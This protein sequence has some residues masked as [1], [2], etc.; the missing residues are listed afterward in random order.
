[1]GNKGWGNEDVLPFFKRSEHNENFGEP[2]HGK[3]GPLNVTHSQQP[4]PMGEA[5]IRACESNGIMR[6]EDYNGAE[7][8]GASMLQFTIKNNLR[9][10]TA[11]AFLKPVM[12]RNNLTVKT[13]C[14]VNRILID[15][16]RATGVEVI[17]SP[18]KMET[19]TC[20]REVI[21]SAGAIQSPQV[22][23]LSG[24]GDRDVLEKFGIPVLKHL[25][26]VG[27]N[28]Q[29][30]VWSGI[31]GYTNIPMGNSLIR[32]WP[33]FKAF[34]QHLIFKK[35]PLGNSPLEAN[36]FLK[37]DHSLLRPDIQFHMAP[38]AIAPGYSTDIYKLD[39]FAKKDGYGILVILLRPESKGYITLRS[40]NPLDAPVI[41]P[42]FFSDKRDLEV[43]L[44]ALKKSLAIASDFA[45][46][47]YAPGPI[48]FPE[49][50]YSDESLKTHIRKSLETLYHPVGTCKMG[51]DDMSVVNDQ[52]QV[53]D[54]KGLRV[55]D[56]SIMPS[57]VSGN[58]NA[59][60]IMIGEK[61]AELILTTME[62]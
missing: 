10:S 48:H 1:L 54:I 5:F 51:N 28:L 26:G 44:W 3:S 61:A 58:T 12:H 13:N 42:C 35:G 18:G 20:S 17:V 56:A 14:R 15:K 55:A 6:N 41:E 45:M 50:P 27:K 24:I 4:T 34:L 57:I 53:Y 31:S 9:H 19:L 22:L 16:G 38:I 29:D 25:P 47:E 36:A 11:S 49:G 52:L 62:Q 8:E 30:H 33:M 40:N 60:C 46:K 7:Q 32:P 21:L 43:L 59:A 2:F 39:T 23:M 37:S